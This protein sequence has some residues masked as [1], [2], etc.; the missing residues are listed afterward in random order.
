MHEHEAPHQKPGKANFDLVYDLEDPREYFGALGAFD[1]CIPQHGQRVF[2]TLIEARREEGHN[3]LEER[4][5]TVV[6]VC[7]SYGVNAALLKYEV[8]LDDLYSRYGSGQLAGLSSKELAEADAAFYEERVSEAAPEVVGVDV[9]RNA[10]SYGIRSGILDAG[11]A[12]NLEEDEPTEALRRAV[13]GS[14]LLTVTGGVGYVSEGTF[15]RLLACM[16]E[17]PEGRIPWV[18]V[19]ALRWV[20]YEEVSNVLSEYGL[21]TEKLSGHTFTQRRFADD[22]EREYVLE[23]LA[24]MGIDASGK[25]EEGWHHTD[26]YLSRPADEAETPIQT[27]LEPAL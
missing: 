3:G 14:D 6:D 21:V 2:S 15:G 23:K 25:E 27:L 20:S 19:F 24:K 4:R 17:G 7:C 1:Y 12:E 10:V 5:A 13:S 9:S 18:A 16:T 8:T 22:A 11:F 26:F